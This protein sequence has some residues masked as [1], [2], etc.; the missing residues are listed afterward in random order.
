MPLLL[1]QVPLLK[2]PRQSE[3]SNWLKKVPRSPQVSPYCS[4]PTGNKHKWSSSSIFLLF[5]LTK[6]MNHLMEMN[7]LTS[8]FVIWKPKSVTYYFITINPNYTVK[9]FCTEHLKHL[10]HHKIDW[11]WSYELIATVVLAFLW[12]QLLEG[13]STL[14]WK[15]VETTLLNQLTTT[16]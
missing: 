3:V 11:P 7:H 14:F 13:K 4:Y 2:T 16:P 10:R 15:F 9:R 6:E 8:N 1:P 12:Q 5:S